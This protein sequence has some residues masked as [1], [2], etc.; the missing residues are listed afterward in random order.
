[1]SQSTSPAVP[2][3]GTLPVHRPQSTLLRS[4]VD[5]AIIHPE[6]WDA[7]SREMRAQLMSTCGRDVL[8]PKLVELGALNAYQA[9]RVN[10]GSAGT[11]V[12]GN[13]RVLGS[14]GAGGSGVIFEAE[15]ILMRRKIALK[16]FPFA[17]DK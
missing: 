3:P 11:L 17:S 10:A 9:G 13:Y 4:L 14:L 16:V 5:E 12:I 15:H 8:L 1:M 7:L 6:D 2:E